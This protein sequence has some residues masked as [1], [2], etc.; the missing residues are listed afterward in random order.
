VFA[1]TK[2]ERDRP[3]PFITKDHDTRSVSDCSYSNVGA[4]TYLAETGVD[5]RVVA[6][7]SQS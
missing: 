5:G 1:F 6:T 3:L 2:T 4:S 7:V